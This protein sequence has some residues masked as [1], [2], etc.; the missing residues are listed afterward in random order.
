MKSIL[1]FDDWMLEGRVGLKRVMGQPTLRDELFS[2]LG[3]GISGHSVGSVFHS[4]RL[5]AYV[6]YLSVLSSVPLSDLETGSNI[7]RLT[8]SVPDVW[9]SLGVQDGALTVQENFPDIVVAARPFRPRHVS[10]LEGTPLAHRGYLATY[11]SRAENDRRMYVGFSEDGLAFD[12]DPEHPWMDDICDTWTGALY[13]DRRGRFHL[14]GRPGCADRR[15]CIVTTADFAAFS[16]PVTILQPDPEDPA[17]TEIYGMPSFPYEDGYVG[18]PQIYSPSPFERR[19]IKTEG[20]VEP[21][22]VYSYNATNWYR[23]GRN[24]LLPLRPLG[25]MGGGCIYLNSMVRTPDDRILLY[26]GASRGDHASDSYRREA[27]LDTTGW[28]GSL[29]YELRLDGFSYLVTSAREGRLRTKAVIPQGP[30]FTLNVR[31]ASHACVRVQILDGG[32]IERGHEP[33]FT[34]RVEDVPIPGFSFEEAIP[35]CGDHLR[36]PVRWRNRDGLAELIGRPVRIEIQ[37]VEAEIYGLRLQHRGYWS[38][39]MIDRL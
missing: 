12:V 2:N 25:E 28:Y 33:A 34:T 38:H 9:P 7:V 21:H 20:R 19:R 29:L 22:L 32:H 8:S 17:P 26:A 13:D 39:R 1:F 11:S 36:A 31:T 10:S 27:G 37:A 5:N 15:V 6:M 3:A 35:I 30:E 16:Q 18:F 4:S 24:P 14:F 23:A